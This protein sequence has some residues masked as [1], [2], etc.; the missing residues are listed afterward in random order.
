MRF[1]PN[2]VMAWCDDRRYDYFV[3]Y[4]SYADDHEF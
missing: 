3:K 1:R 4:F 2:E